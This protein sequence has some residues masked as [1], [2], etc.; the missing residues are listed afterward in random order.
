MDTTEKNVLIALFMDGARLGE[1]MVALPD[2]IIE[3]VG[4]ISNNRHINDLH[5]HANWNWL[6][7]VLNKLNEECKCLEDADENRDTIHG[8]ED[9]I[10]NNSIEDAFE[11]TIDLINQYNAKN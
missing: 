4:I 2:E 11:H 6:I 7:P 8:I 5:Y 10:W 3:G 9:S 1:T